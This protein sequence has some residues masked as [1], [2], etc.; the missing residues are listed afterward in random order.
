MPGQE[1]RRALLPY[2]TMQK[3]FPSAKENMLVIV[4]KDGMIA[5]A[6]DEVRMVLRQ[7]RRVKYSEADNFW[8][9]TA[10]QMIEQFRNV[11]SMVALVMF[12]M[13]SI[14]L[15]VGGSA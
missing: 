5:R 3:M 14:G 6:M 4:A 11:T 13:S 1:D 2:F 12:S 10:E 7:E 9:S 8:I 15:L